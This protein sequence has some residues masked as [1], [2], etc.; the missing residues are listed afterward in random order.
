MPGGKSISSRR[1][2]IPKSIKEKLKS[3]DVVG[4]IRPIVTSTLGPIAHGASAEVANLVFNTQPTQMIITNASSD[5][6]ATFSLAMSLSSGVFEVY[7][8]IKIPISTSL[9]LE[10]RDI[11]VIPGTK[12]H[13]I[14]L[15]NLYGSGSA[16]INVTITF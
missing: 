1:R 6:D 4:E 11:P 3:A 12:G 14:T 10:E 15:A 7:A 8:R 9:I 5:A 2:F 16:Q 13:R